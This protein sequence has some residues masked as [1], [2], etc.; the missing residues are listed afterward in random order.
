[1][2][3][4][5]YNLYPEIEP[6]QSGWLNVSETHHIY[7]EQCGNPVGQP[8]VFL[9]G[10]PG[11]GCNPNQRRFFDPTHY[12]IILLDQRGCGRS[13]P[14][15]CVDT[16]TTPD[17]VSDL[18]ALRSSLNIDSWLVFGGSWGSTLAL[19][20][21]LANPAHVTGLILR[22]IFLSRPHELTWFLNDAKNFFPEAWQKLVTFLP[23]NERTDHLAAYYQRI[24]HE[25]SQISI[26]A[27]CNW[28]AYESSIMTLQP[29]TSSAAPP[30]D[31]VQLARAKVQL[32]YIMNDC[33]VGSRP[34]LKEVSALTHIPTFIVQGRYD[35]VCPPQTA[36]ELG[37]A[38]PHAELHMISDAGHSAMEPGTTSMLIAATERFKTINLDAAQINRTAHAYHNQ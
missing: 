9:H 22:G 7:Y 26:P 17:L 25:D 6:Y 8:V 4:T 31:D 32:H 16:N 27:A 21:A 18:D 28:N 33:F 20:Y 5:T 11:S 14:Q 29:S 35:M 23:P 15:G 10:G 13:K 2:I 36:W 24:F 19:A 1:M 38:M 34:I 30:A 3:N 12:R 37:Q